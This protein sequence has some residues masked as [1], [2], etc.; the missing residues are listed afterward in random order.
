M[1]SLVS[2]Q[3][4]I[5]GHLDSGNALADAKREVRSKDFTASINSVPFSEYNGPIDTLVAVSIESLLSQLSSDATQWLRKRATH[6]RRIASV[7]TGTFMLAPTGLLDGKRVTTHWHHVD[8]LAKQH[9]HLLV[10][11]DPVLP[12]RAIW[13]CLFAVPVTKLNI[14]PF[15][16][17]SQLSVVPACAIFRLGQERT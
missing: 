9:P 3:G 5:A 4:T 16:P 10:K 17:S 2:N 8:K 1:Q 15:S 12:S 13:F 6:V 14:A 7:C 11:K